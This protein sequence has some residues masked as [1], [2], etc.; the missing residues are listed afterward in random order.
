M[1]EEEFKDYLLIRLYKEE[2]FTI[3]GFL[4]RASFETIKNIQLDNF[5]V[6]FNDN[7]K[8]NAMNIM[9]M[10]IVSKLMMYI[11]DLAIFA[12]SFLQKKNYYDFL[13][14]KNTDIGELT[15]RFVKK[16][17]SKGNYITDKEIATIMSFTNLEKTKIFEDCIDISR[18]YIQANVNNI[19]QLL[20][21]IGEFSYTTHSI[22]QRFKH[23]GMPI[24]PAVPFRTLM[25]NQSLL[26]RFQ[27]VNVASIGKDPFYDITLLPFS[28]K[29]LHKYEKLA[30]EIQ[31]ILEGMISNKIICIER[32]M[33]GIF[34]ENQLSENKLNHAELSIINDKIS[35]Y[36]K[37]Y[38]IRKDIPNVEN[39]KL[40]DTK[41]NELI[42]NLNWYL[43]Q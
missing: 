43:K 39:F 6:K 32:K 40:D 41:C 19:R 9:Q 4:L 25:Q 16:I 35:E 23:A 27:T 18:K 17:I 33:P 13:I 3:R 5:Y 24:F 38:E 21:N 29:L 31:I 30:A 36:N 26:D 7:E 28:V 15:G 8:I 14:D 12:E 11:E 10:D 37:K 22:Y 1:E 34:P 2:G 20:R 42:E